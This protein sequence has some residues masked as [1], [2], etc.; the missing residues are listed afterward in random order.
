MTACEPVLT[1]ANSYIFHT[2]GVAD[3]VADILPVHVIIM[4]QTV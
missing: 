3:W 1:L 2:C 4:E